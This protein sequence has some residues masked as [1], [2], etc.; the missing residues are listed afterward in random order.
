MLLS[1][2]FFI[3]F[4]FVLFHIILLLSKSNSFIKLLIFVV[5]YSSSS[6][7][8]RISLFFVLLSCPL[9]I[10]L[11]F[12]LFHFILQFSR[13]NS[14]FLR[15]LVMFCHQSTHLSCPLIILLIFG[16]F[17]NFRGQIPSFFWCLSC[18]VINRLIF[19]TFQTSSCPNYHSFLNLVA[20]PP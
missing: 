6:Y 20:S 2:S 10:L 13:S 5:L 14:H 9:I 12:V 15:I 16:L 3:P 4:I 11:I 8:L 18:S 17:S 19:I 1:C 7:P